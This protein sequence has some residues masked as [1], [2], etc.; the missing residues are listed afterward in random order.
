MIQ[1]LALA[2]LALGQ[3]RAPVLTKIWSARLQS[4]IKS[5]ALD[6]HSIYFGTNDGYGAIDQATG[7]KRWSKSFG[8]PQLIAHVFPYDGKLYVEI[9]QGKLLA[10]DAATGKPL[11]S[12]NRS[13]YAG[14]IAVHLGQLIAELQPGVLS[15]IDIA[16]HKVSWTAPLDTTGP[17]DLPKAVSTRP[18]LVGQTILVGTK[19]GSVYAINKG[20]GRG[21][22]HYNKGNASVEGLNLDR[23]H[24]YAAYDDGAVVALNLDN[25]QVAWTYYSNSGM[26]GNP[27]I[28]QGRLFL[29]STSGS[30][31]AV[32]ILNGRLLWRTPLSFQ[33]DFGISQPIA[34]EDGI[35][36]ADRSKLIHL[37]TD[38]Q[39]NWQVD[40]G[41]DLSGRTPRV[42]GD[43]LLLTGS[44]SF[45]RVG[46][47]GR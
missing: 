15:S 11:W 42:L 35:L 4:E 7:K 21:V 9:G 12:L 8:L 39:I 2:A 18:I 31:M 47:S 45:Y 25:G 29:G 33:V 44:H 16:T 28:C 24:V 36:V 3:A 27:L 1:L 10:C 41:Q 23:E 34:W 13:G 6:E 43:G 38:G 40:F 37:A 17:K 30:V 14:P 19:A 5:V 46:V 32:G 22:W 20:D 26:F